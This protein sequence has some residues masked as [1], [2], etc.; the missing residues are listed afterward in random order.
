M[1]KNHTAFCKYG[2][3]QHQKEMK[4][5]TAKKP[6]N[7]Q[8]ALIEHMRILN[9][10][11]I[12]DICEIIGWTELEY[13]EHQY[14]TYEAFAF[15]AFRRNNQQWSNKVR[16]SPIFRGLWNNEWLF[17]NEKF[18]SKARYDLFTGMEVDES[19]EIVTVPPPDHDVYQ[20][21][22]YEYKTMHSAWKLRNN[23]LFMQKF[24]HALDLISRK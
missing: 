1:Q 22:I 18:I 19:G 3:Y 24:Y 4:T 6:A 9:E 7:L 13:C 21:L 17:R 15:Y 12:S 16:Y 11:V 8:T 14:E 23:P 5:I 20:K 10:T 2:L